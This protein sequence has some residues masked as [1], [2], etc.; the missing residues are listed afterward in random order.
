MWNRGVGLLEFGFLN[1][2]MLN[3]GK[4]FRQ[5][6]QVELKRLEINEPLNTINIL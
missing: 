6:S 2:S 5:L 3:E 1:T 4:K